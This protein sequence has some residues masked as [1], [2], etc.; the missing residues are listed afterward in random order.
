MEEAARGP[1][2]AS[3]PPS[4]PG[5]RVPAPGRVRE[6]STELRAQVMGTDRRPVAVMWNSPSTGLPRARDAS[7]PATSWATRGRVSRQ[8][9]VPRSSS[10][11]GGDVSPTS[12]AGTAWRPAARPGHRGG[13]LAADRGDPTSAWPR[14]GHAV[15]PRGLELRNCLGRWIPAA[16]SAAALRLR[17]V[18]AVAIGRGVGCDPG[19]PDTAQPAIKTAGRASFTRPWSPGAAYRATYCPPYFRT[20]SYISCGG[21]Y[22]ERGGGWCAMRR[23]QPAGAG[24]RRAP[25]PVRPGR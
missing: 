7:S 9:G 19:E 17:Q 18:W 23:S 2:G 25:R 15:L 16:R 10:T 5:Q 3:A 12:A 13:R 8:L 14:L 20:P 24:G 22:G 6:R 11:G 1:S 4:A 21:L